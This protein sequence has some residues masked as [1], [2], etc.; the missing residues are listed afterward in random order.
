LGPDLDPRWL[1][2]GQDPRGL[3]RDRDSQGP[4]PGWG[5]RA[6][7]PDAW[8]GL[9]VT[10]RGLRRF[11]LPEITLDG[12]ACTHRECATGLLRLVAHR[13]VADQLAFVTAHPDTRQRTIDDHLRIEAS[14]PDEHG[15]TPFTVRLT[16]CETGSREQGRP[17]VTTRLKVTPADGTDQT[18]CLKIGPP[19]G[20]PDRL[21]ETSQATLASIDCHPSPVLAA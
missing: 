3:G 2:R 11:A 1:G 19:P 16:P 20:F 7:E 17:G 14:L 15:T 5:P 9:S 18:T 8:D 4:E 10:S 13:L 6:A 12:A 21:P